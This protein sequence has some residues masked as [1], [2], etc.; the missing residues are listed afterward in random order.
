MQIPLQI[1]FRN[2]D[3]SP[4]V[5]AKVRE[6]AVLLERFH[7]RI[8]SCRV[9]VEC[10][11]HHHR[12]GNL[13]HVN[14]D[15]TVPGA[16]IVAGRA[17]PQHQAHED[18]YVALRDAFDAARRQLENRAR[19][20]RGEIKSHAVP[21]HGRISVLNSDYGHIEAADGRI[22]YFHRN[23]V[24]G[25]DFAKLAA[26]DEVRFSDA[27]GDEGPQATTVHVVGKHH[28]VG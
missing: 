23:S 19:R 22:V 5:E 20:Q 26:G 7:E 14:I 21:A 8:T 27:P 11:H 18:V 9:V 17:A 25:T 3:P 4:A 13:Y 12:Q 6:R 28:I 10:Q 2:M 24:V 16:E 1:T 15:L